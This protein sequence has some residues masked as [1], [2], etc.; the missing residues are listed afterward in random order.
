MGTVMGVVTW[1]PQT[2]SITVRAVVDEVL[3]ERRGK[4]WEALALAFVE[5][6]STRIVAAEKSSVY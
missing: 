1:V 5:E 3:V 4:R 2:E 6:G